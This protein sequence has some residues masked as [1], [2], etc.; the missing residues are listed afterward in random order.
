MENI[1]DFAKRVEFNIG[2]N[3]FSGNPQVMIKHKE[4]STKLGVLPIIMDHNFVKFE[5]FRPVP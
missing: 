1:V 2:L 4:K 3:V 5:N